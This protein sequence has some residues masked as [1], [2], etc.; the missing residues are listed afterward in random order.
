MTAYIHDHLHEDLDMARLSEIA[1]LSPYHWHRIYRAVHGE[2]LASTVRRLRLQEAA[3]ALSHGSQ[4]VAEIA[5]SSGYPNLQ[6]FSRTF[7]AA[8]GLPPAEFRRVGGHVIL[9]K[10][11]RTGDN[12][13]YDVTIR[14]MQPI[15]AIGLDHLGP[16]LTI[17]KAF[18]T[19][20]GLMFSR[21]LFQPGSKMV[22][23]YYDDPEQGNP[24]TLR[25]TA[26][27][28][29]GED[30]ASVTA[31]LR[32]LTI[33]G[34]RYAVLAHNGPYSD[35][36]LAYQW[37]YQQWLRSADVEI[38]NE[39]PVEIYLNTPRDTAPQDLM[40]EICIPII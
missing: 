9:N 36:G 1:C 15:D 10:A 33:A 24:E 5:R 18:E 19:L 32:N 40:T 8:Y 26:C 16:Y 38:R 28:T 17:G 23:V 13:M 12:T 27:F 4:P 2:T 11:I 37:L 3:R 34:G 7:K 30:S 22:A 35:L 20:T 31:P 14:E 21:N 39:P 29:A 6:S 25:S